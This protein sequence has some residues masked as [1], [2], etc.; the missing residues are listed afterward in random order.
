MAP[1]QQNDNNGIGVLISRAVGRS[2]NTRRGSFEGEAYFAIIPAIIRGMGGDCPPV[3][4]ALQ[5]KRHAFFLSNKM[6]KGGNE[7]CRSISIEILTYLG[8]IH[9]CV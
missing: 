6:A 1:Y 2:E 4:T 3:P 7:S 5:S 9:K 8:A